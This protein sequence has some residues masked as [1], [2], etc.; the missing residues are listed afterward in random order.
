MLKREEKLACIISLEKD[1]RIGEWGKSALRKL[2]KDIGLKAR[3]DSS[4]Q[5][6]RRG[7]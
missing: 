4:L 5:G 1:R 3:S 2:L 6:K 7:K